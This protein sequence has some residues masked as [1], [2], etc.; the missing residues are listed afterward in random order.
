MVQHHCCEAAGSATG[1]G[2]ALS[3]SYKFLNIDHAL[4]SMHISQVEY[5]SL[6]Q[7]GWTLGQALLEA[8]DDEQEDRA[9]IR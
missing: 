4:G 5:I 3:I 2:E 6:S 7:V 9:C 8:S 1:R